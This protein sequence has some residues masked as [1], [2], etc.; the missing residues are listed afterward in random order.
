[1]FRIFAALIFLVIFSHSL[2]ADELL[3]MTENNFQPF[4][5]IED[6]ELKGI[7]VE[8][9]KEMLKRANYPQDIEVVDWDRAYNI[10]LKEK[11]IALFSTVRSESRENLFHWIGPI[12]SIEMVFMTKKSFKKRIDSVED[13]KK[14]GTIGLQIEEDYT[15]QALKERGFTNL[16]YSGVNSLNVMYLYTGKIDLWF[17]TEYQMLEQIRKMKLNVDDFKVAFRAKEL[18]LDANLYVAISKDSDKEL[19]E[20][21]KKAF[22][23][24]KSD[25]TYEKIVDRYY[26]R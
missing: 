20:R 4:N 24:M 1:M 26:K 14:A 19:I 6:G 3:V 23:D 9:V 7:S 17:G 13:L 8:S 25:G 16:S 10:A 5:Y 21:L 22:D 18:G 12:G 2:K 15:S 11:N